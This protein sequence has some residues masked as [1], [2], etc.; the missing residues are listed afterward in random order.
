[1]PLVRIWLKTKQTFEFVAES[2]VIVSE[3]EDVGHVILEADQLLML[4]ERID[5]TLK[6]LENGG[7]E[8]KSI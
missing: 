5:D 3:E 2:T 7:K 1:M 8:N 4:R 6:E